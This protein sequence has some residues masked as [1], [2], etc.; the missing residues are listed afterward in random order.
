MLNIV[1]SM[2]NTQI[3]KTSNKMTTEPD[4]DSLKVIVRFD[5]LDGIESSK[6][7][8]FITYLMTEF[9]RRHSFCPVCLVGYMKYL[10]NDTY[11]LKQTYWFEVYP[12]D[13]EKEKTKILNDLQL[14]V[15]QIV[16]V[17]DNYSV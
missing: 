3:V 9:N 11:E 4:L 17:I 2:N 16:A 7:D 13:M 6:V 10:P 14:C 5:I 12:F 8:H 1:A 15:P